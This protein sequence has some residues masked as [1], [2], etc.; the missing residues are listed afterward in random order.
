MARAWTPKERLFV[1]YYLGKAKGN[2]T[3]AAQMAGY[4]VPTE[5]AYRLLRKDHISDAIEKKLNKV[6]MDQEEVLMRLSRLARADAGDFLRFDSLDGPPK[7]DMIKAKRR[8]QLGCIKKL[9]ATRVGGD[10]PLE[11]VET[12]LFAP[13]EALKIFA[14]MHGMLEDKSE[15]RPDSGFAAA[16]E[17]LRERQRSRDVGGPAGD[18]PG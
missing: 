18:V 17:L 8:D 3:L 15:Q 14:K 2:G 4:C 7:L 1:A 12:E 9:K 6:E 13:I 5:S 10:D 11:I 16:V